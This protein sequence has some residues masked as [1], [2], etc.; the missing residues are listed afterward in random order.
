ME[1]ERRRNE[2]KTL[3]ETN[4]LEAIMNLSKG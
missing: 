2:K 4:F 1:K 3:P